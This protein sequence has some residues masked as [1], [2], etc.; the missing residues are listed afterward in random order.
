MFRYVINLQHGIFK[1][2]LKKRYEDFLML[3]SILHFYRTLLTLQLPEIKFERN[4]SRRTSIVVKNPKAPKLPSFPL[5]SNTLW[6]KKNVV[7][8][9]IALAGYLQRV[10][11]K[12]KF[13][14]FRDTCYHTVLKSSELNTSKSNQSFSAC[15]LSYLRE[16]NT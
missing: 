13:R 7:L 9:K 1:W 8:S 14:Q 15:S 2:T 16:K 3:H 4:H 6:R 10:L 11:D 12:P 5:A